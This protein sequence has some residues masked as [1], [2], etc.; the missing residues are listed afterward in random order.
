MK[1]IENYREHEIASRYLLGKLIAGEHDE[2]IRMLD[3]HEPRAALSLVAVLCAAAR[4]YHPGRVDELCLKLS[5]RACSPARGRCRAYPPRDRV[6][7]TCRR[8]EGEGHDGACDFRRMGEIEIS[9]WPMVRASAC[10][11]CSLAFKP[12]EHRREAESGGHEHATCPPRPCDHV[13]PCGCPSLA[14]L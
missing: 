7:Y 9:K 6:G 3:E 10:V 2:V 8:I 5:A 14:D 1:R 11:T 12:G 13:G 4:D